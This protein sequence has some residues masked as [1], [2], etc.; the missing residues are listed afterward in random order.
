MP[1][2]PDRADISRGIA[3]MSGM[4]ASWIDG[5]AVDGD[6]KIMSHRNPANDADLG[7]TV[8]AD[9]RT[10]DLAISSAR[11]CFE[12]GW[13]LLS[14][15]DRKKLL[16]GYADLIDKHADELTLLEML[17]VGRPST[18]AAALNA[19]AGDI[20]RTYAAKIDT[21]HGDMFRSEERRMGV[22]LRRPRGVVGAIVPW[23][24]PVMNVLLRL[25]PALAAGN[26]IVVKAS[27]LCPRTTLLLA[28]LASQAGLPNGAFNVVIGAGPVAGARLAEH[29]DL[30]LVAF[31]GSSATGHAVA[32][33]AASTSFKPVLLECGGK[34]PQIVLD[35]AFDDERIWPLLFFSA[36]WNTGQWCVAKTRLLIPRARE[37]QAIDGL[38]TAAREWRIGDP[39]DP[40][41]RLGPLASR[42]QL[43]RVRGY[44]AKAGALGE[45][46]DLGCPR[47]DTQSEGYYALPSI[48]TGLPRGSI[49]Q[50][51]EVFGPLMTVELFD[52]LDDAIG[53]ANDTEFGLSASVWTARSDHGYKLARNIRAGG[54]SIFSSVDAARST[55]PE[56][57]TARYFEPQKESGLGIDGG[58]HGY[59]AYTTPQSLYFHN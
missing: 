5:R 35:D 25:A 30:N 41:T 52:G 53:L 51:E 1:A 17:E 21:V 23:N 56:L 47:G 4:R 39:A 11:R 33:A 8:M 29:P 40:E 57:G 55:G 42:A 38:M 9:A 18:D 12:G 20:I 46:I 45:V 48:A 19:S 50:K 13:G 37:R 10:V 14:P 22:V 3:L 28:R 59:L 32:R 6:G 15:Y 49:L 2:K 24:V 31:T 16:L 44:Y 34:S 26:T 54:V 43:A 36:F 7:D 27:E 58:E